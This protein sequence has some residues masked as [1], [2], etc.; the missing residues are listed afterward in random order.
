MGSFTL[1]KTMSC[2]YDAKKNGGSLFPL[3]AGHGLRRRKLLKD[4]VGKTTRRR[5]VGRPGI[6][7][8]GLQMGPVPTA[9]KAEPP[10]ND[11]KE[12]REFSVGPQVM[13]EK[14][15]FVFV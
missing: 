2:A 5:P 4:T 3:P 7:P 6:I 1:W 13:G 9:T 14:K 11:G 15:S 10:Q 8:T 12:A